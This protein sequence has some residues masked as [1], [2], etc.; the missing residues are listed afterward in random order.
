M[1][2]D[3]KATANLTKHGVSF[4]EVK[5]LFTERSDEFIRIIGAHVAA[6]RE[7]ALFHEYFESRHG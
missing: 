2:D 4:D 7:T 1:W 6:E 5:E 3:T